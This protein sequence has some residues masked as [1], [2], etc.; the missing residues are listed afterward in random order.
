MFPFRPFGL[1][2]HATEFD[3]GNISLRIVKI[4]GKNGQ[5]LWM[6]NKLNIGTWKLLDFTGELFRKIANWELTDFTGKKLIKKLTEKTV[7][8]STLNS[9]RLFFNLVIILT[10]LNW[11]TVSFLFELNCELFN[12]FNLNCTENYLILTE[13]H[14][15]NWELLWTRALCTVSHL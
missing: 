4:A 9:G 15:L 2:R 7:W 3:C 13:L 14:Y 6:G 5:R 10:E 11:E 12:L 1:I 8:I